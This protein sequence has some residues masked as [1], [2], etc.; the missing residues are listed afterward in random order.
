MRTKSNTKTEVVAENDTP[1]AAPAAELVVTAD[2]DPEAEVATSGPEPIVPKE[3]KAS[4]TF[5]EIGED[6]S[7]LMVRFKDGRSFPLITFY[8][9]FDPES[10]SGVYTH[11]SYAVDNAWAPAYDACPDD[12]TSPPWH[13]SRWSK[14]KHGFWYMFH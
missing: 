12:W 9:K 6:F 4:L 10:F 14:I 5:T 3:T 7:Q 13:E 1:T 8:G 2:K 11:N